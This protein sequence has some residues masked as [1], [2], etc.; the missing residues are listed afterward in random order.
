MLKLTNQKCHGIFERIISASYAGRFVKPAFERV[1][2]CY[3]IVQA[4]M[5]GWALEPYFF[6]RSEFIP[7]KCEFHRKIRVS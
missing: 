6:Y 5:D 1:I 2:Q 4:I 7:R 3:A